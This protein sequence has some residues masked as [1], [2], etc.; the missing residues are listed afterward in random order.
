MSKN[1]IYLLIFL[2]VF[3]KANSQLSPCQE[4]LK[5]VQIIVFDTSGRMISYPKTFVTS[6][7]Q[8][9]FKVA[10]PINAYQPWIKLLKQS[11]SKT[12]Q[13][14]D[15]LEV[16][17][18]YS[19]FF[20]V[21][22]YSNF[23]K[24]AHS[25]LSLSD[26]CNRDT[27]NQTI[28]DF[29]IDEKLIPIT[30]LLNNIENQYQ[31]IIYRN[32]VCVDTVPLVLK[33]NCGSECIEFKSDSIK[34]GNSNCSKCVA[35]ATD[36]FRFEL[37]HTNP[38]DQTIRDWYRQKALDFYADNKFELIKSGLKTLETAD[39]LEQVND[40]LGK[41]VPLQ[42]WFIN[43]F[44]FNEG[45]LQLDPFNTVPAAGRKSIAKQIVTKETNITFLQE[46][47]VF[48]DS[49]IISLTKTRSNLSELDLVQQEKR[50]INEQIAQLTSEKIDLQ[51]LLRPDPLLVRLSSKIMAYQGRVELSASLTDLKN[52]RI[53][54]HKQFDAFKGFRPI[55]LNFFQRRKIA[56]IPENERLHISVHNVLST[57][58]IK[59]DENR[60]VFND[61]EE[62]TTLVSEQLAKIDFSS[63]SL[64]IIRNLEDFVKS[65]GLGEVKNPILKG[66]D[67]HNND[68]IKKLNVVAQNALKEIDNKV[69]TFPPDNSF[70]KQIAIIGPVF[71]THLAPMTEFEAPFRNNITI[72]AVYP[73]D[74]IVDAAKTYVK[75]GKLRFFQF[76]A[77]VAV[78]KEPVSNTRIDTVGGGFRVSSSNNA[79]KAIFGFKLYPFK[80]YNRDHGIIPRYPLRRFSL[81]AGAELLRPLDNFYVG[82]AY[83]LIPG[84]AF[85]MG[86]NIN[87]QTTYQVQNNAILNTSRKYQ[88][89]GI[90]YAVTVNPVL[91]IQFVKLFFK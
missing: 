27:L 10:V 85:S 40:A 75:V 18:D 5:D 43:W 61:Q 6:N 4:Y 57:V 62:F 21:N 9:Q 54:P 73:K 71:R 91:F 17:N 19:C 65:F 48:L 69:V 83:D 23:F 3:S 79:A 88:Q 59:V 13:Y 90:Y 64:P 76:M 56:E 36:L 22:D 81:F 78:M 86:T 7:T 68:C 34:V 11:L 58:A 30:S 49:V 44:W 15:R 51:N 31:V 8:F 35:K 63:L 20:K 32:D 72:K 26:I 41:L 39:S 70:F 14:T 50:N 74:V 77:G 87:L 45:L 89:S 46:K 53:N 25:I 80:N 82:G 84:L 24:S 47:L 66:A 16:N 42:R 2:L 12:K 38:W 60:V 29:K 55:P 1:L 67:I 52:R 33:E 28:K 37:I